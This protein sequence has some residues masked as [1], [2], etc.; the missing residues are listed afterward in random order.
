[1]IFGKFVKNIKK[2]LKHNRI[3]GHC[4]T[5][6]IHLTKVTKWLKEN[7]YGSPKGTEIH[8]IC[9]QKE[10]FWASLVAQ[11]LRICLPMQ[12]T[13]VRALV[14]E[15]PTCCGATRPVSHNYWA[16]RLEP[17]LRNK[18]GHD[19]ERPAH[20]DEEWP[21]LAATRESPRT[22]TKT[23]HKH[24]KKKKKKGALLTERDIKFQSRI[25]LLNKPIYLVNFNLNL[26]NP[27]QVQNFL[28]KM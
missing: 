14:W 25:S 26:V 12:G 3:I 9:Y 8:I 24:K 2:V 21:P 28:S 10:H 5:V 4:E 17:V 13:R 7:K 22:E 27:D 6:L 20:R 23:Q 18:R 15:D 19:S 16:S 1:M 11:W